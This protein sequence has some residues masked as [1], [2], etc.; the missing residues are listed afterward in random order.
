MPSQVPS[1]FSPNVR[2]ELR[3]T[4][5]CSISRLIGTGFPAASTTSTSMWV[6]KPSTFGS[7]IERSAFCCLTS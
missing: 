3:K 4:M 2:P 5:W 6:T 1:C 7:G